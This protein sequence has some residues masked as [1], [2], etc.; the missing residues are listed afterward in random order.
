VGVVDE[1]VQ[2]TGGKQRDSGTEAEPFG[3]GNTYPEPG[4]RPGSL[5]YANGIQI[6]DGQTFLLKDLLDERGREGGL[7][8][9]LSADAGG[10]DGSV[11]GEGGGQLGGRSLD[12]KDTGHGYALKNSPFR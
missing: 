7:H 9:G 2:G 6:L 3:R 10:S 8:P 12:E 1:D 11:L 4:I 5:A